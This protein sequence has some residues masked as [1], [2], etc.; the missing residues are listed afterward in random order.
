MIIRNLDEDYKYYG[1]VEKSY[2]GFLKWK[3]KFGFQ[4]VMIKKLCDVFVKVGCLEVLEV[5]RS[6]LY[7]S[8]C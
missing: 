7:Q 6:M 5:L 3:E 4:K 8:D 1:V 2:Q